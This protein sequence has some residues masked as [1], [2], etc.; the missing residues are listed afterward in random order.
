MIVANLK[1][2][3]LIEEMQAYLKIINNQISDYFEVVI[4]PPAIYLHLLQGYNYKIGAQN[5]YW[6]ETGSYTGEI[7]AYQLKSLAVSFVI[8]GHS[9]RR[10]HLKED[11]KLIN[12]KLVAILKQ[13][14]KPILCVGET[15]TERKLTRTM[16]VLETQITMALAGITK[17]ALNDIIIAYEPVWA[18]GS[19]IIPSQNEIKEAICYIKK[20][21]FLKYG[22][23]LKVL[24]GG[25]VNQENIRGIMEL[26]EVDGLLIGSSALKPQYFVNMLTLI[27]K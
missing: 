24:Y 2:N 8:V 25:S 3:F 10:L 9:E 22:L 17:S 19:G 20:L 6:G 27:S 18:I 11:N 21:I 4:C 16:K 14:I 26:E 7:S 5:V 1:M 15:L 12:Q 23:K 13:N